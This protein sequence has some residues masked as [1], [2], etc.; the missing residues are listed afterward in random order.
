VPAGSR[1]GNRVT[2]ERWQ[3]I[4]RELHHEAEVLDVTFETEDARHPF[5][6]VIALHAGKSASAIEAAR[7]AQ[8]NRPLI[9]ALTGTDLYRDIHEAPAAQR[10]LVLADR[11]VVLH[12]LAVLD[13]PPPVRDKAVVIRQSADDLP[14]DARA[15]TD[16][17]EVAFVAHARAEKDPLRAALAVRPLPPSSKIRILHAGRALSPELESRLH[18]EAR[19]NPRYTWLGEV[20][21]AE[22]RAL[23]ARAKLLVL[24]SEMEGGANVLGE[25]IVAGT[26]P[27]ATA[28]PACIAALGEDYPGLFPVGDT[29]RLT[30]L[31]ARAEADAQFYDR[32][33]AAASGRRPLFAL[34]AER[35]AWRAT[36][37]GL[38]TS[39]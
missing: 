35:E 15:P 31:L 36:L 11:L 33:A 3:R 22:A 7:R 23:I 9:V 8:P 30:A 29:A 19:E 32:L 12:D 25:A 6:L 10:S 2:A 17:F 4:L 28:I 5:E 20:S 34:A 26:P 16:D 24:T 37:A 21:P 18:E 39:V 38:A 27:I 14:E 13:L 1:L